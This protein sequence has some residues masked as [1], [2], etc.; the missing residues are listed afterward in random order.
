MNTGVKSGLAE[1]Q[2][3]IETEL[4]KAIED[5]TLELEVADIELLHGKLTGEGK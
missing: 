2:K 3:E 4:D 1:F 5:L